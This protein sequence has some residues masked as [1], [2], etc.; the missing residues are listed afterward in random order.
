MFTLHGAAFCQNPS[1]SPGGISGTDLTGTWT[2]A[3]WG[4]VRILQKGNHVALSLQTGKTFEGS[5]DG[6]R[7][8]LTHELTYEETGQNLPPEVR[9]ELVKRKETVILR[10]RIRPDGDIIKVVYIDKFPDWKK[11]ADQYEVQRVDERPILTIQLYRK[12]TCK[13]EKEAWKTELP[14]AMATLQRSREI[15][16]SLRDKKSG[17]AYW[18]A[19][20]YVYITDSEI[21]G[22]S[23]FS[24]PGFLL[25]FIPI[26]YD[27]YSESA[28]AFVADKSAGISN[29][30]SRHFTI[31]SVA[32]D[33]YRQKIQ[34]VNDATQSLISGVEAHIQGDMTD[35]LVEAYRSY[36]QLYCKVPALDTYKPDF[37]E[38]NRPIFE[39]VKL[40]FVHEFIGL[41]VFGGSKPSDPK[42]AAKLSDITNRGLNVD[43]VYRWRADAWARADERI[44]NGR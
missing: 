1:L 40:N 30:W 37:F 18:F 28:E 35:A 38:T 3:A 14:K 41:G 24:R 5:V 6:V 32:V 12:V 26:F 20:L 4:E 10:G 33:P 16:D 42:L 36:S 21:N 7:L 2:T 11:T 43:E 25:H 44:A 29:N 9:A 23:K 8:Q 34:F 15:A 13:P 22:A 31:S 19:E 17:L 39:D 27:M